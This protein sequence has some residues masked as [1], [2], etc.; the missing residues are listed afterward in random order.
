MIDQSTLPPDDSTIDK[1]TLGIFIASL[2]QRRESRGQKSSDGGTGQERVRL[3]MH[4]DPLLLG[5][6]QVQAERLGQTLSTYIGQ[7]ALRRLERDE[8]DDPAIQKKR[9]LLKKRKG[10]P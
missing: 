6:L 9:A 10:S 2:E 5:R 1:V 7:A 4:I 3:V 8:A